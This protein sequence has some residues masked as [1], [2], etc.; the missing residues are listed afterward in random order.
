MYV[1]SIAEIW[2]RKTSEQQKQ[3]FCITKRIKEKKNAAGLIHVGKGMYGKYAT[4]LEK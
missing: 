3:T 2:P 1:L 4:F